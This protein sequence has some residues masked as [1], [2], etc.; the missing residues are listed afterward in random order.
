MLSP[1]RI[2]P[3][4]TKKRTKKTSKTYFD[5]NSYPDSD[6]KRPQMTSNDLETTQRNTKSNK[7]N[8]TILKVGSMHENIEINDQYLDK[9][10]DN[11]K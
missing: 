8:E 3:Y 2:N 5:N 11:K 9:I 6:V 4:N 1:Y 7:K 10:L